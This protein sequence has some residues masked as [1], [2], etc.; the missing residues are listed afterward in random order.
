M[1]Q[2][3]IL[4]WLNLVPWPSSLFI[5]E[6]EL[7]TRLGLAPEITWKVGYDPTQRRNELPKH[8]RVYLEFTRARLHWQWNF[9]K[10]SVKRSEAKFTLICSSS[11]P[12]LLFFKMNQL[13]PVR[14]LLWRGTLLT[15]SPLH[16]D[17]C[18]ISKHDI[19]LTSE[20]NL[21]VSSIVLWHRHRLIGVAWYQAI[22]NVYQKY[23]YF[24]SW[25]DLQYSLFS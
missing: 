3:E 5:F 9:P 19:V 7:R 4:I 11:C 25:Q 22:N 20:T 15:S 1:Q 12:S 24:K 10:I 16:N 14:V 2:P 8:P 23:S 18:G 13:T 21:E 6:K 17:A